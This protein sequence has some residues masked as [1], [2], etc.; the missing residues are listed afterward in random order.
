MNLT[1]AG[2]YFVYEH[3]K[4]QSFYRLTGKTTRK[5]FSYEQPL[6]NT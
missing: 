1:Q 4:I 2:K 5:L 6:R 3:E